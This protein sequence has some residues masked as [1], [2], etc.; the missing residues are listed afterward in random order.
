MITSL[1]G[2]SVILSV[3]DLVSAHDEPYRYVLKGLEALLAVELV[4]RFCVCPNQ[5]V[6]WIDW[7]NIIDVFVCACNTV[8]LL[9]STFADIEPSLAYSIRVFMPLTLSLRYLRRFEH[10]HLLVFAFK[11][12]VQALPV[13]LYTLL[14]IAFFHAALIYLLEPRD[15]HP[16]LADALWFT[17]TTMSTVGYATAPATAEG[18]AA[19]LT[20]SVVSA[21]YLAI[22]IGIMGTAFSKAWV[23]RRSG[24]LL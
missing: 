2:T 13:L 20:L 17:M 6:F 5:H 3:L 23:W 15:V 24:G 19:A 14:L 8:P 4:V 12:V 10:F 9:V 11:D 1:I 21:L 18:K 16:T 22:P 7:Y